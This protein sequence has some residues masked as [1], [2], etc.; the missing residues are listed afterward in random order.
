[1]VGFHLSDMSEIIFKMDTDRCVKL[2]HV[3][4]IQNTSAAYFIIVF[5]HASFDMII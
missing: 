5:I 2:D 4:L 3:V 1:M